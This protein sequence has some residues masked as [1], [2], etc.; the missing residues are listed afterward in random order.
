[1]LKNKSNKGFT[2]I[3]V[4]IVLAIAGLILLIV[5]LA[6]PALQRNARNTAAKNDVQNVLGGVS[7]F[8]GANNGALP[9]TVAGTGKITY[10]LSSGGNSTS[11][12]VQG[13]TVVNSKKAASAVPSSS[14]SVT[15]GTITVYLGARCDGSKSSRAISAEYAI[16]TS[17]SSTVYQCTD[18]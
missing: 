12:N 9:D 8:E 4:L 2:I 13:T 6:V 17:S 7:E 5:F 1:M 14:N 18:S 3:E 16:E 10:Q 15:A 11:I